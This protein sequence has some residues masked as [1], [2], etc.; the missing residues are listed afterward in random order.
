MKRRICFSFLATCLIFASCKNRKHTSAYIVPPKDSVVVTHPKST[1][2]PNDLQVIINEEM[3]N[4]CF[5]AL[6]PIKGKEPYQVLF[7]ND[8]FTWVLVNPQLHLHNG[9]ANFT[10]DVNVITKG[11]MYSTPCIGDVSIWYDRSKNLI[12]VKITK[13]MIEIYTKILGTKYHLKDLDLADNFKDPFTFEG[14]TS[15]NSDMDMEM[16]DGSIRKLYITTTDCDLT[17]QEKQIVVPCEL[18]FSLTPPPKP[19]PAPAGRAVPK[20]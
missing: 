5:K 16:P 13:C 9:K 11:L 20:K 1:N 6:G 7:V 8:S 15:T 3:L 18:E 2:P 19:I 4:K 17:V 12:N 10:T 14:P